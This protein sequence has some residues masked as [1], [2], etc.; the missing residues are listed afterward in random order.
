MPSSHGLIRRHPTRGRGLG[1]GNG[2]LARARLPHP[3]PPIAH[4]HASTRQPGA[5]PRALAVVR[6]D[7]RTTHYLHVDV[8]ARRVGVRRAGRAAARRAERRAHLGAAPAWSV[9]GVRCGSRAARRGWVRTFGHRRGSR[10]TDKMREARPRTSAAERASPSPLA[11]SP[12]WTCTQLASRD[13]TCHHMTPSDMRSAHGLLAVL[14]APKK[15]GAPPWAGAN[16]EKATRA[17][18]RVARASTVSND[19]TWF[20]A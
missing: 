5:C 14:G 6:H 7:G 11:C 1:G 8:P 4:L 17:R 18:S 15:D 3:L 2:A 10:V 16:D 13:A 19:S 9:R 20:A 12:F